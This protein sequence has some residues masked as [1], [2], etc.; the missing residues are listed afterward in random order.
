MKQSSWYL[1]GSAIRE[2]LFKGIILAVVI[3]LLFW[4]F[5]KIFLFRRSAVCTRVAVV[6]TEKGDV[7]VTSNIPVF[8]CDF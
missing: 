5:D 1:L 6:R 8:A 3:I 7:S 2:G 4:M